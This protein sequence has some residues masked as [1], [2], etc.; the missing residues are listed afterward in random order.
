MVLIYLC[1]LIT[2]SL[3]CK[4]EGSAFDSQWCYWKFSLTY[5]F[6]PHY[7]LAVDST[8]NRN[9]YHEYFLV[10]KGGQCIELKLCHLHVLIVLKSWSLNLLEPSGP[11][12]ACIGIN[13]NFIKG[14]TILGSNLVRTREFSLLQNVQNGSG[15][16][17]PHVKR[18]V[19]FFPGGPQWLGDKSDPSPPTNDEVKMRE[20]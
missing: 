2:R 19:S 15:S 1:I 20:Q 12:Q 17:Q 10:G 18:A 16:K 5:F 14:W 8:S 11:V 7:G 9:G 4:P 3:R 6:W 13:L